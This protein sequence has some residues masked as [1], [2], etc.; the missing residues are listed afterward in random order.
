[1]EALQPVTFRR[2]PVSEVALAIQFDS[3]VVDV[4]VLGQLVSRLKSDYP[5]R[6]QQP[7]LPPMAE[8]TGLLNPP[9]I[10]V[11]FGT[12]F[13]LGRT[14]LLTE[15]GHHLIQIQA[16]RLVVNWRRLNA[17]VEY[18]RYTSIRDRFAQLLAITEELVGQV[19]GG[20]LTSNFLELSYI[21]EIT[22]PGS[23]PGESHPRV[24]DIFRV[25]DWSAA[26]A[27]LGRPEDAQLQAR[28]RIPHDRLPEGSQVGRL[29][30]S[31]N[32]GFRVIDQM[33]IYAV[34]LV[35]RVVP[36]PS[37]SAEEAI[38]AAD[39]GHEW[40][41]RGFADLTTPAM[42]ELWELAE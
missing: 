33:P 30:F 4:E 2:P 32:P 21:N 6:E 29:Y 11:Q 24:E 22:V 34:N 36:A 5:D 18:P 42:H 41:V 15:D 35:A 1:M 28:W 37:T 10:E 8:P 17:D 9:Q 40:I 39:T 3:P 16:D 14:W 13:L 27:F 26:D 25:V 23:Q 7:A 20:S 38:A 12:P 19:S 31:A